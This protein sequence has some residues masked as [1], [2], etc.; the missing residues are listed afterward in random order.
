MYKLKF[1][2][3]ALTF[4]CLKSIK[5][6]SL[7]ISI[8]NYKEMQEQLFDIQSDSTMIINI[9]ASWCAPC[10]LEIPH[11]EQLQ[12]EF[13]DK[14][15]RIVL[16]SIDN[17]DDI[18]RKLKPYLISQNIKLEVMSWQDKISPTLLIPLIC[19]N[20]SGT[21]PLTIVMNRTDGSV[22]ETSFVNYEQ[23]KKAVLPFIK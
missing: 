16:I 7:T 1:F 10:R 6:Q 22:F 9:W 23:L 18:E 3:F 21:I 17:D 14:K 13:S 12:R 8:I 20:W 19:P 5:A 11:F 2:L 4:C 15:I